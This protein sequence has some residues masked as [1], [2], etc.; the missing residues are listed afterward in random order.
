MTI[1]G[2][3]KRI[4]YRVALIYLKLRV[5]H[6]NRRI[7]SGS[8]KIIIN[9]P[10]LKVTII[11]EKNAQF[12]L[13]GN[14]K[15]VDHLGGETP[16]Y[17]YISENACLTIKRDFL[18]GNGVRIYLHKNSSLTIGGKR[19]ESESGITENSKIMV[20]KSIDIGEDFLCA[21]NVFISDS[22]WHTITRPTGQDT[23]YAPVTIGD[24]VWIAP[25]CSILKGT[26]IE[27][28]SIIG[29]K[30]TLSN[31]NYPPNSLIAGLPGKVIESDVNWSRDI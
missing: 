26:T 31:K 16:V 3:L 23:H 13:H 20:F 21:W 4:H 30:T 28:G 17:I 6:L 10:F 8:G 19:N 1:D 12:I 9:N 29:S 14:L 24:H 18:I 25:D 15:I 7:S 27:N 2:F 5:S 22:D 11:L